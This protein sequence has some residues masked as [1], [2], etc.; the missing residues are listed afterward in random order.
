MKRA[1]TWSIMVSALMWLTSCTSQ[2]PLF[3]SRQDQ[4]AQ[5]ELVVLQI[6]PL[7]TP[8]S[9][10]AR[11]VIP[12]RG[13]IESVWIAAGFSQ[14]QVINYVF[15][16]MNNE[17]ELARQSILKRNIFRTVI[18][19]YGQGKHED[20][21]IEDDAV[22]YYYLATPRELGWAMTTRAVRAHPLLW[23]RAARDPLARWRPWLESVEAVM[24]T[25]N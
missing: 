14:P 10:T 7:S 9:G 8:I 23:D 11:V 5:H 6:E 17:G 24:K 13:T 16:A 12:S 19:E 3:Q 4:A 1:V 21:R 20:L 18:F 22:I 25:A 2:D 15:G